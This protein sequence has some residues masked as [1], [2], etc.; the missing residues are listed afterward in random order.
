MYSRLHRSKNRNESSTQRRWLPP[1]G[2][3]HVLPRIVG[4]KMLHR[5]RFSAPPPFAKCSKFGRAPNSMLPTKILLSK[6]QSARLLPSV[7]KKQTTR[8][9]EQSTIHH[10]AIFQSAFSLFFNSSLIC[11]SLFFSCQQCILHT[12]Q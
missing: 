12:L 11:T 7:Q 1:R 6:L 3:I 5:S 2:L 4:I 9:F 10:R 8:N